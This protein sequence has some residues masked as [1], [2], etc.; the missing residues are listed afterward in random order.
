MK[1]RLALVGQGNDWLT[2]HQP[3]LR[4][5]QDRFEVKG[6][7]NSVGVLADL[8]AREFRTRPYS[9]FRDLLRQPDIDGIL[10]LESDWYGLAP[11]YEACHQGK[12]IYCASEVDLASSQ[13]QRLKQLADETG[14]AILTE[15]PRRF[16]GATLRLKELIA[17]R[18][19][20]PRLLF[21]HRRLP[22]E[23]AASRG[24]SSGINL[25]AERELVE[26]IDW[27]RYIV[28]SDPC[29][30][31]AIRHPQDGHEEQSD[32]QILSL[33]FGDP[34]QPH[35]QVLAQISCGAYIPPTWHEAVAYRPPAAV[36]VCCQRGLAFVDLP[37]SLV[38]FDDAGR[39]QEALDSEMPVG[40]QLLM[41]FHRCVTSL[42][43]RVGGLDDILLA[44]RVLAGAQTSM[45]TGQR[46]P[47]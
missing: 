30:V 18:L 34:N 28:G 33:G 10:L 42:V 11:L 7:Y 43:R 47:L 36:Q 41:Q 29:W 35:P 13:T 12:A 3:A 20:E 16:A 15:L 39:Q 14:V 32:Y 8:L 38:W 6:V 17:T 25:R 22:L 27:C 45:R 44:Q 21:C 24:T 1:L 4:L 2:R 5:L 26:L 9:S 37:S 19:G 46:S 23:P 40:Q 31:S